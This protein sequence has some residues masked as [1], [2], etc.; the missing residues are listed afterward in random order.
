[1]LS[2]VKLLRFHSLCD[3]PV[4]QQM[5]KLFE[6]SVTRYSD[7]GL[8]YSVAVDQKDFLCQPLP[9]FNIVTDLVASLVPRKG[10][11]IHCS[12]LRLIIA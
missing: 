5:W 3:Q 6:L 1:M 8:A 11:G 9:K 4:K 2:T 7:S 12:R 10:S